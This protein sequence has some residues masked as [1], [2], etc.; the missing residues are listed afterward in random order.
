MDVPLICVGGLR[1]KVVMESIIITKAADLV[2][3]SRPLIREPDL[4]AKFRDGLADRARCVSCN[5]CTR[6]P[7]G[8]LACAL[9]FEAADED[10]GED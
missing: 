6:G 1:T 4:P 3:L 8:R 10:G 2:S 5:S 9:D 7:D